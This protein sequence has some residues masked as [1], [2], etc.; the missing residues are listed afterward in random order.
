MEPRINYIYGTDGKVEYAVV[1]IQTW[2]KMQQR[3]H[4]EPTSFDP[5]QF[6]GCLS[7]G[8]MDIERELLLLRK[9]WSRDF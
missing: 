1:P 5:K 3:L 4:T 2:E 8:D 6:W 7:L 9:E